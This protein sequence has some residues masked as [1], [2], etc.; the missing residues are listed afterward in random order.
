MQDESSDGD[1]VKSKMPT[2]LMKW[3]RYSHS[4]YLVGLVLSTVVLGYFCLSYVLNAI[5]N[6]SIRRSALNLGENTYK[7]MIVA[8]L[9]TNSREKS[10]KKGKWKSYLKKAELRCDGLHSCTIHWLEDQE[11]FTRFSESGRGMELSS[12]LSFNNHL[13]AFEDRT[14]IVYELVKGNKAIPRQILMAGDGDVPKGQKSEWATVKDGKMFVGSFGKEYV[15]KDGKIE[16]TNYMWISTIDEEGA[17]SHVDWTDNYNKLRNAVHCKYPGYL[18]HEAIN[19]SPIRKQWVILPRRVS[20]EPYDEN[21]DEKKGSN[22]VM[23]ASENFNKIEVKHITTTT[24]SR[25]FSEFKFLPGSNDN[26]I[27]AIKSEENEKQNL[28]NSFITV[29]TLDGKI[30]LEE[31][32]IPGKHKFEGLEFFYF[33][34]VFYSQGDHLYFTVINLVFSFTDCAIRGYFRILATLYRFLLFHNYFILSHCKWSKKLILTSRH[35]W[36]K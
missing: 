31:T 23:L 6:K 27:V 11:I 1:K 30:L 13:Y 15:R 16:H 33:L 20:E 34:H 10:D 26:V 19:W 24:P 9:D 35:I 29:F 22:I 3:K 8:D 18:I 25:G 5:D 21:E 28:Q 32:E 12:L 2:I 7:L 4:V 36:I 17:V 14:G